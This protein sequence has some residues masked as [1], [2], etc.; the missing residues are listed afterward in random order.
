VSPLRGEKPQNWP[1]SKLNTGRFALRA[2]LPVIISALPNGAKSGDLEWPW[3]LLLPFETFLTPLFQEIQHVRTTTCLPGVYVHF[4]A[5]G[6]VAMLR[7][8]D[9]TRFA[10]DTIVGLRTTFYTAMCDINVTTFDK[11]H[12]KNCI[13]PVLY[14]WYTTAE[15]GGGNNVWL[16]E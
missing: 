8:A 6:M 14:L 10:S 5:R 4:L 9:Q 1:L 11:T 16:E 2:M 15:G 7:V 13:W 3:R 12:Q